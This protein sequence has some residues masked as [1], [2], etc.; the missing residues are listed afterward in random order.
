MPRSYSQA[1]TFGRGATASALWAILVAA[2]G[3]IAT[4]APVVTVQ[5]SDKGATITIDGQPFAEYLI[6]SGHQPVIWPIIGPEGQAMTRQ[7][8]LGDKLPTEAADH[9]HHRSLW[10]SHG[11]VNDKDFWLEPTN[12]Q[13]D[14]ADNQI[15]HLEFSELASGD[16]GRIVTRNNWT[17]NGEKVCQDRRTITF[18]ANEHG[19]WIDFCVELFA[20]FG[21]VE[22]GDTKEGAFALRVPGTMSVD[23]RLG[24]RILNSRGQTDTEAWGHEAEWVD[25]RG[26]VDGK[27]A[28]IVVFN[29]PDSFRHPTRWHV[30]TYGLFAANPFGQ[31]DF[32]PGGSQQGA[33]TIKEGD[34]V[35]LHY[36][37][38][39]YDG[40]LTAEAISAMYEEFAKK[41]A[42]E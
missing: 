16:T 25:Y 26:P 31:A 5:E 38:L 30:R 23:S 2:T 41:P 27:T 9:P 6:K 18:G 36:C 29:L 17:S 33:V 7:Y 42:V 13:S 4:A 34:A 28:G 19:R 12:K 14:G 3:A 32:S 20:P 21:P 22:W 24:G 35:K 39:F 15:E 8:P 40:S 11:V 1:L 37:V 10:F